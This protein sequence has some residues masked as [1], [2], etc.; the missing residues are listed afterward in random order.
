MNFGAFC[1]VVGNKEGMI[2]ISELA[3]YRVNN[4]TDIL[5]IGDEVTIKVIEIDQMGRINLSKIAADR[6]LG[7]VQPPPEGYKEA[8]PQGDGGRPR[9]DD[10]RGGRNDRNDRNHNRSRRDNDRGRDR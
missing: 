8:P 4:V 10:R 2:H 1:T 7:Q 5:N 9:R 3:D 6:E